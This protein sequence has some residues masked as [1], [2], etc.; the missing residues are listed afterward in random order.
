MSVV[1]KVWQKVSDWWSSESVHLSNAFYP[2]P[3]G[4]VLQ[5]HQSYL[6]VWLSEMFLASDR[7][8]GVD[9]FPAVQ[10]S[11]RLR[12]A[13]SDGVTFSTMVRPAVG[14][15]GPGVR[16]D[17]PLTELLPY[18]GGLLDL[19]VGLLDVEGVNHVALALDVL[20]DFATL[21]VPPLSTA[22]AV[23]DKVANGI[24]R[25]DGALSAGGRRPLLV[26]ERSLASPGGGSAAVL[27]AGCLVV[28]RATEAE[29][30]AASCTVVDGY[31]YRV[32]DGKLEHLTGHDYMVV[33]IEARAERDDWRFPEWDRLI[34]R[35]QAAQISGKVDEAKALRQEVLSKI[36]LSGDLTPVD[37]KRVGKLVKDE[38]DAF[39]L[40]AAGGERLSSVSSLVAQRGLPDRSAAAAVTV[41]ELLA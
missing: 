31:L 21:L 5:P 30:P 36:V 9:R 6:R 8:H 1:E 34:G 39:D 37:R 22:L 20:G 41:E 13:G 10:A 2:D 15:E 11:V 18:A 19:Q 25:I 28:I 14:Q 7:D 23:A 3:A 40:G 32:I 29:V 38:L 26:L 4:A 33:R 16:R 12:F 17:R 35:S 24:G 27:Q